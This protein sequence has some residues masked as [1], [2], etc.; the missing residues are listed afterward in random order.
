MRTPP[1]REGGD[2]ANITDGNADNR[3]LPVRREASWRLVPHPITT[4]EWVAKGKALVKSGKYQR[5]RG[6]YLGTI[7][8]Y[9]LA[10]YQGS[11]LMWKDALS[12][13]SRENRGAA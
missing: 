12:S 9:G 10:V 7:E 8:R 3:Q 1:R 11:P 5:A 4:A 6:A 2:H 13:Q